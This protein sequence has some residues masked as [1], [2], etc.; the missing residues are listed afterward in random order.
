MPARSDDHIAPLRR[1]ELIAGGVLQ[2]GEVVGTEVRQGVPLEPAPEEFDWIEL[3]GIAGQEMQVNL[4]V[5]GGD[6]VTDQDAAMGP[7]VVP[8]DEQ[9]PA[10]LSTQRLEKL[11]HFFLGNR[12]FVQAKAQSG[13]MHA[14]NERELMP[15]EMELHDR[16]LAAHRPS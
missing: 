1:F 15:L 14:G 2:F 5:G 10:K 13:E 9:R 6:V 7:G 3:G 8:N 12:A 16:R 4:S 11:D